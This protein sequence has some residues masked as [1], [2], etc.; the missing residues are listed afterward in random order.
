MDLS[1]YLSISGLPGLYKMLANRSNGLI[2]ESLD[3]GKSRF[4]PSR[5]HGFTPLESISIYTVMDTISLKEVFERLKKK[6]PSL[7]PT[8]ENSDDEIKAYFKEVIP[9]YDDSRVYLKDMKK[10]FR[11]YNF[12]NENKLLESAEE[13]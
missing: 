13:E 7:I 6:D 4:V 11:W 12:L 8:S 3:T 2:V 9:D 1:K 5:K 10:L